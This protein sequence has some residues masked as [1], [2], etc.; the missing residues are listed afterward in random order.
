MLSCT[1]LQL[2]LES[3]IVVVL[4]V[5]VCAAGQMLGDLTPAVSIS[6]VQLQDKTIFLVG[7][8]DFLDAWV[9]VVVPSKMKKWSNSVKNSE[10][11]N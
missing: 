3:G 9:Q 11:L 6:H 8:L 4:D 7:P 1:L 10:L 2:S 5:V